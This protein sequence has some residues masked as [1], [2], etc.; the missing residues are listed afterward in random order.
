MSD[1]PDGTITW[2]TATTHT[3]S[4]LSPFILTAGIE[5]EGNYLWLNVTCGCLATYFTNSFVGGPAL[6]NYEYY[7][8]IGAGVACAGGTLESGGIFEG[9]VI[10]R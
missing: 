7:Q 4:D 6:Y 5:A 8:V 10:G 1:T 9:I 3:C 2:G